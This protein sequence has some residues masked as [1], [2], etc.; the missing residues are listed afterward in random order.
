[1]NMIERTP[2]YAIGPR[3]YRNDQGQDIFE[4]R[5]D[6]RSCVGPRVATKIDKQNH[7][8]QWAAHLA[9]WTEEEDRKLKR[10]PGRPRKEA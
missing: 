7:P 9:Q 4:H 2:H 5:I 3:F 8:D 6:S 10:G 1:M